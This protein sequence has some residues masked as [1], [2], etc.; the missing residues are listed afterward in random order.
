M[1]NTLAQVLAWAQNQHEINAAVLSSKITELNDSDDAAL[2][3]DAVATALVEAQEEMIDGI[4]AGAISY[5]SIETEG[6]DETLIAL[7]DDEATI[8]TN[9]ATI[10]TSAA[11]MVPSAEEEEPAAIE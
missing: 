3:E 9:T 10:I 11:A 5:F 1:A 6:A 7:W 8:A 2:V 4:V